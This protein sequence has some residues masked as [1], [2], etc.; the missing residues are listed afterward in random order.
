LRAPSPAIAGVAAERLAR[1]AARDR[2]AARARQ[3]RLAGGG[4]VGD[5][6]GAD[7]AAR[8]R[9]ER[10]V[11]QALDLSVDRGSDG[12]VVVTAGLALERVRTAV[13]DGPPGPVAPGPGAAS[14]PSAVVIDAADVLDAPALGLAVAVDAERYAGP[15]V[16][17]RSSD[18]AAADPR[19]GP[20]PVRV[21]AR[22]VS[23]GAVQLA[24]GGEVDAG[25]LAAARANGSLVVIVVGDGSRAAPR[26][27]RGRDDRGDDGD[28]PPRRRGGRR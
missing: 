5:R 21:A 26:G 22:R 6:V 10:A 28:A 18:A 13:A 20:T 25:R 1:E 9:F 15:T 24:P 16:F 2:A 11:T 23:A 27:D 17:W 7:A 19:L 8:R 3:L 12:S 4:T 14:A